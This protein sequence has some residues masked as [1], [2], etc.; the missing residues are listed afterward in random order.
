MASAGGGKQGE[1]RSGR[2]RVASTA[3][4]ERRAASAS[5][6]QACDK[7]QPVRG[8]AAGSKQRKSRATGGKRLGGKWWESA[9][10][11]SD[12]REV[13]PAA[14][15][16]VSGA[17]GERRVASPGLGMAWLRA[18]GQ[19]IARAR[20]RGGTEGRGRRAAQCGE[21]HGWPVASPGMARGRAARGR[22]RGQPTAGSVRGG[23]RR[24]G[25]GAEAGRRISA[26]GGAEMVVGTATLRWSWARRR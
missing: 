10:V 1:R 13:G 18:F 15:G 23:C 8:Q 21:W 5:G 7:R 19:E 16:G 11:A 3:D 9:R 12:R 2:R 24:A 14:R 20:A 4:R 26:R 22:K 25:E 17:G 6:T